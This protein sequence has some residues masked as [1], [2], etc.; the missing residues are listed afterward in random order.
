MPPLGQ[1][2]EMLEETLR[3][4]HAGWQGE[5]GS[6][7]PFTGE[8]YLA[9]ELLNSPQALSRPHPPI[10]IG[11]G[12]ERRTLKL[13]ARYADACNVFGTDPEQLH[14]KFEVLRG[15]CETVGRDYDSIEKTLL[16][17][18]SITPDG[19]RRS[20]TPGGLVE[21]L[22][23]ATEVGAQHAIFSVRD[24]HDV[25]KLE[26]IGRDVIPQLRDLGP[27]SPLP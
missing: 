22:G 20:L 11:G 10:L 9:A 14:H 7:E 4:V 8:H 24:V 21:R 19:A 25:S 6:R 5:Q 2:F 1:R 15:H 18:V 16:T 3:I 12:G 13:V 17:Q 23:R 27:D 26:L